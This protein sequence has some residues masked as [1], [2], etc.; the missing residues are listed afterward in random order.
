MATLTF[1]NTGYTIAPTD[2]AAAGMPP[3]DL[4][5]YMSYRYNWTTESG[6]VTVDWNEWVDQVEE[7]QDMIVAATGLDRDD[8]ASL[9]AWMASLMEEALDGGSWAQIMADYEA[10]F[11]GG[12]SID[13]LQAALDTTGIAMSASWYEKRQ[14]FDQISDSTTNAWKSLTGWLRYMWGAIKKD[15]VL[16]PSDVSSGY[17]T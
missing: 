6:F 13:E 1:T 11:T 10:V 5:Y 17:S 9:Y 2:G 4:A 12:S 3:G 7:Y 16:E 15:G 14:A 8:R